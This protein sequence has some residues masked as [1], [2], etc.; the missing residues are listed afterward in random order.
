[1]RKMKKYLAIMLMLVIA[2][3][4]VPVSRTEAKSEYL[5]SFSVTK[6]NLYKGNGIS[7]SVDKAKKGSQN[8]EITF[9]VKNNSDKDYSIA[10]HEYAVNNLMAGGSTYMSNV[11]VPSGKKARFTVLISKEWFKANGIKT[12]KKFDVLFWGYGDSMKEWESPT[13]SFST[14][15][16]NGKG[17]YT[18]KKSPK[19]SDNNMDIG[20]VSNKSDTYTFYVK[21]KTNMERRWTVKNCSVN[22]WSYDLGAAKYDLYSEPILNGCYA[23]FELPVDKNFKKENSIKKVKELEFSIEF[24][25]G[26]DDDYNRIDELE[27]EKVTVKF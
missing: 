4:V 15:K 2:F 1:M 8:V 20:Y 19:T 17:Y 27:S 6:Q 12:F 10:A 3:S 21:N 13:V 24:E 7:I 22:G 16:D 18:P 5:S 14:N 23:V 11:T 9:L 25:G 26:F